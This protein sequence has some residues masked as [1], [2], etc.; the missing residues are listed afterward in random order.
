MQRRSIFDC[1]RNNYQRIDHL[2]QEN[3]QTFS[4]L[5]SKNYIDDEINKLIC[6]KSKG[7]DNL[8]NEF[9]IYDRYTGFNE[10]QSK[11]FISMVATGTLIEEFNNALPLPIPKKL[12]LTKPTDYL[13]ISIFTV[14]TTLFKRIICT[15]ISWITKLNKN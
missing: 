15:K 2:L 13:P 8:T 11:Y 5:F 1:D 4:T 7:V 12:E 9:F 14:L 10:L 6:G 3:R